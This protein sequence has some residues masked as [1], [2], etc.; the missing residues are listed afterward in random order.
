MNI[1]IITFDNRGTGKCL[2]NE[3]IDLHQIGQ[4]EISRASTIEFN[5][6]RQDWEVKDMRRHVL[7]FARTRKECI[8]WEHQNL[9]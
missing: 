4:L 1:A 2:Y 6:T 9:V 7:F 8:E 3:L 5:N